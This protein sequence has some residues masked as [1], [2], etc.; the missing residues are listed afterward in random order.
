MRLKLMRCVSMFVA[1]G[2]LMFG[3]AAAQ[4]LAADDAIKSA[5]SATPRI[6]VMP[7]EGSVDVGYMLKREVEVMLG[8]LKEAGFNPVIASK[9]TC[10]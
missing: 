3:P 9:R 1:A 5:G 4:R 10:R 6:L 2:F 8:M 7:R